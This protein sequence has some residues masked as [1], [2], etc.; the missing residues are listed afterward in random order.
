MSLLLLRFGMRAL[1]V[2]PDIAFPGLV[3]SLTGWLVQPF[4]RFFP[5]PLPY[6]MRFDTTVVEIASLGAAAAIAALAL[7]V[8]VALLLLSRLRSRAT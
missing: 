8:Y 1:A 6:G 2:R 7:F 3:Y 5:L 4:Y